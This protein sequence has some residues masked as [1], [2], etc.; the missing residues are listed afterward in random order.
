MVQNY[1]IRWIL[2]IAVGIV[3][4]LIG[5]VVKQTLTTRKMQQQKIKADS[6][7]SEAQEKARENSTRKMTVWE[8][9]VRNWTVGLNA[10]NKKKR[11]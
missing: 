8:N 9:A 10:M 6:I 4:F 2:P 1:L 3:C 5:F 7:I 11:H